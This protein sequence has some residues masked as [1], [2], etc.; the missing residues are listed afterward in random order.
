MPQFQ[1]V[2]LAIHRVG[3][4]M[5]K[6][7]LFDILSHLIDVLGN[8]LN[9]IM[10]GLRQAPDQNVHLAAVFGEVAGDFLAGED[11]GARGQW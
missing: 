7:V 2:V 1:Q 10:V 9:G 6:I 11:V 8:R 3:E 5:S 4:G